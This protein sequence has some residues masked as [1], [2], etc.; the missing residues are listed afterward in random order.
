MAGNPGVFKSPQIRIVRGVVFHYGCVMATSRQVRQAFILGAGLGTRLRPLTD[1]LPKPLVPLY[2]RPLVEWAIDACL[3][4]GI[5][6]FAIN[7]HH[8]PQAWSGFAAQAACRDLDLSFFYEPL[9][10]DTGGGLRNIAPWVADEPLLVHNGDI[11]TTMPLEKLVEAHLS[12]GQPATLAL[13]S[14]G[15]ERR[16]GLDPS[17]T[18]VTDLRHALGVDPGSHVFSGV[19]CVNPEFLGLLPA[20]GVF[21]VIPTFVELARQGRLGAVVIDEG[22]WLDL[23]DRESYLAANLHLDLATRI[24]PD[25]IVMPGAL[26]EHSVVGP[27]CV[28]AA[29][30][31][32]RESVLWPG[33][34]VHA[35]ASLDRCVAY[36]GMPA[37]GAFRDTNI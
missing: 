18:R 34:Q 32:V 11:F 16:V 31:R 36:S 17:G 24:H 27:G 7:T 21:S 14:D 23:G 19:Y 13:R 15:A 20:G 8:L 12:G 35:G 33:S 3:R 28:I 6:R 37:C 25:A 22:E 30:A 5:H 4:A 1:R 10:L 2:N 29:G 26:V 9:L